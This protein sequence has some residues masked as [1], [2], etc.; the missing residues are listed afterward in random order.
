M[1][2]S[3]A[4]CS[5]R[6]EAGLVIGTEDSA[7]VFQLTIRTTTA[8]ATVVPRAILHF[9][10]LVNMQKH[11]FLVAAGVAPKK[12]IYYRLYNCTRMF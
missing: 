12:G 4:V 5:I 2:T 7:L 11:A 10:L 6:T 3:F 1:I 9:V 8:K